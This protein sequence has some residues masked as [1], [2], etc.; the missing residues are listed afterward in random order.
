M[1]IQNVKKIDWDDFS[2][3]IPSFLT[4]V[5]IPLCFSISDGLA[6]GFIS[7]PIV[8]FFGG[9]GKEVSWIMY[10]LAILLL[11]YFIFVRAQLG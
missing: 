10:L 7:Y 5:G 9:R 4:I 8:K 11:V 1:M 2:E 6:M 3:S